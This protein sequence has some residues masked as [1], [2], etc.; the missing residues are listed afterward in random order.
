MPEMR[1]VFSSHINQIGFDEEA[2]ELHVNFADGSHVV[3][4][5]VSDRVAQQVL[6]AP[7]IGQAL[8]EGVRGRFKFHYRARP[9]RAKD[10]RG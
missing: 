10:D 6:Q 7:S 8:H 3:Y 9:R 5:D 1:S 2:G 4:S